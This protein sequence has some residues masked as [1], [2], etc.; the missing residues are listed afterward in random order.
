MPRLLLPGEASAGVT[1]GKK[2]TFPEGLHIQTL[3]N[4]SGHR[5]KQWPQL[6]PP[7]PEPRVVTKGALIPSPP[8]GEA[9]GLPMPH[10]PCLPAKAT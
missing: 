4:F 7:P 3:L 6:P 8:G 9:P 2:W 1:V 5:G 10:R